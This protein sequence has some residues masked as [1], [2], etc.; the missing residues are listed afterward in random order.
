MLTAA[1]LWTITNIDDFVVLT[2]LFV[3][4]AQSGTPRPGQIISGQYLGSLV[5]I[6]ISGGAAA[7]LMIVP[8]DWVG[9]L[10]L[11]PLTLG[12]YGLIR[13]WR[14]CDD[15][16]MT[17]PLGIGSIAAVI[18]ANGGDNIS[19]YTAVFRSLP[20][21]DIGVTVVTFLVLVGVWC[22][23]ARFSVTHTTIFTAVH[24]VYRWLVPG[25]YITMG[26]LILLGSGVL[27]RVIRGS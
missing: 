9:L 23:A 19:I 7:G 10:G 16:S 12:V 3:Q 5:V 15:N 21:A 22:L 13:V 25:V 2:A 27:V 1:A 18:I 24:H 4:S 14:H 17:W 8:N 11:L 6:M 20:H 26:F